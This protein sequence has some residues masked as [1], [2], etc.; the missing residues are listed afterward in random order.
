MSPRPRRRGAPPPAARDRRPSGART[1]QETT[2][3]FWGDPSQLPA[4]AP[5]IRITEDPSAVVRSLGPPP[6]A[7]LETIAEHYFSVVYDRAVTLAV[8][9]AVA[10]EL[11]EPESLLQERDDD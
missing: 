6:L 1:Q 8:A 11:V 3:G 10:G 7:G 9:L 5:H 2:L 4:P